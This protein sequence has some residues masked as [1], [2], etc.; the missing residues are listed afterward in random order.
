[1][2]R[3]G[4]EAGEAGGRQGATGETDTQFR[5]AHAGPCEPR[6]RLAAKGRSLQLSHHG[7]PRL[8][9]PW[10]CGQLLPPWLLPSCPCPLPP[11]DGSLLPQDDA[12]FCHLPPRWLPTS[13][14]LS[15]PLVS[16]LRGTARSPEEEE[17]EEYNRANRVVTCSSPSPQ[18]PLC[19]AAP[20]CGCW[21]WV[22]METRCRGNG[23]NE[24]Q[25]GDS[26][27]SLLHRH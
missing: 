20:K 24:E 12:D 26:K 21:R 16:N 4:G 25:Q 6:R 23:R 11:G 13:P 3:E 19:L 2:G 27:P 8:V 22:K 9:A 14:G 7:C 5:E 10:G 15:A 18:P 1:M 17:E